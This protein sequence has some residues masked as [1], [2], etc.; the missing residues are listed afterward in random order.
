[1][2]R[3]I[4]VTWPLATTAAVAV[5]TAWILAATWTERT[6]PIP[7]RLI[8]ARPV[9]DPLQVWASP[10]YKPPHIPIPNHH[11]RDAQG[12]LW[13]LANIPGHTLRGLELARADW[14]NAYLR[15]AKFVDCDF[16]GC[17]LQGA[18][19]AGTTFDCCRLERA[20]LDGAEFDQTEFRGCYLR[21]ARIPDME[22]NFWRPDKAGRTSF[23]VSVWDEGK[24]FSHTQSKR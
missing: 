14:R 13:D 7:V 10:G 4:A 5:L 2:R 8:Q 1:M 16:R 15:G 21:R 24:L 11:I 12:R 18:V 22:W 20:N 6:R 9:R 19:L 17:E 3:G 23:T